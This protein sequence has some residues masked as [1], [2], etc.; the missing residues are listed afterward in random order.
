MVAWIPTLVAV[1][2]TGLFGERYLY[3]PMVFG[4]LALG[5]LRLSRRW[6]VVVGLWLVAAVGILQV[7]I[8]E[9][10]SEI[11]LVEQAVARR[12]MSCRTMSPSG[13]RS[14]PAP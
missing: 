7:R 3:L 4:V 5:T 11:R 12:P 13:A 2:R 14:R 6:G 9:W 1:I 10:E 8:P